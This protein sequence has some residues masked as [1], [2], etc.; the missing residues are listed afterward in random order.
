MATNVVSG[1][2]SPADN[3]NVPLFVLMWLDASV[4]NAENSD[5]QKKLATIYTNFK[6]FQS[7]EHCEDAIQQVTEMSRVILIVSGAYGTDLVPRIHELQQVS[8][9][10]VFCLQ[11]E[12]YIEFA[13]QYDKIKAIVIDLNALISIIE[14]DYEQR[15][16]EKNPSLISI[17]DI[18]PKPNNN[19][20]AFQYTFK[21]L[22]NAGELQ[23]T[24]ITMKDI[25]ANVVNRFVGGPGRDFNG[26]ILETLQPIMYLLKR[27]QNLTGFTGP[28]K[29]LLVK[30]KNISCAVSQRFLIDTMMINSDRFL[31]RC[32]ISLLSKR[33]PVPMVQPPIDSKNNKYRSIPSIIHIWDY[34]R[35]TLL[36]FGI[37]KCKGKTSLINAVFESN[38]EQSMKDKY[39]YQ[40][41][42]VDFGYNFVQRRPVN[43]ADAHGELSSETLN[44]ISMIF[45]GFLV[46]VE[47]TYLRSN[48][49]KVINYIKLVSNKSYV[50]LLI[51]DV[52]DETDEDIQSTT[53]AIQSAC[54]DCQIQFLPNVIDKNADESKEKV[55]DLREKI[56]RDSVQFQRLN[57]NSIR[58]YL[59]KL[60]NDTEKK[61]I[62][63]D[64]AFINRI[65]PILINGNKDDYPLYSLYINM[66][67]T[68][69]EVVKID[70][71]GRDFQ[72]DKL[73]KLNDELFKADS[74]F[75][76][77][78]QLGPHQYGSGF[79][80]FLELL[81]S[82]ESRLTYLNLLSM[83]LKR[84][85]E[86]QTINH[87]DVPFYKQLSL[88]IHWRNAIIG[89]PYLSDAKRQIIID[90]YRDYIVAGN[91]FEIVD[92][93]NFEMQG[94][95][96]GNVFRLFP[97]K[98]FFVISVI[99]PQNSGKSTLLNFLFGTLFEAR[100]GRCTKG[101][102]GTLV[103]IQRKISK[104]KL[105]PLNYDYI[106]AIDT[107]GL[108][109]SQKS[110]EPYDKKLI[111][112]CLA[113][114]HLVIVNVEG[115]ILEPVKKCFVLCAQALK[116]LGE[117]RVR[118]P[119]VHFVLNKRSCRN[120]DYCK[121]LVECV[122][123]PLTE[124]KLNNE[125]N[126]RTEN[127]HILSQAFSDKPFINFNGECKVWSTVE[128][129]VTDVQKIC[130]HFI[131]ISSGIIRETGDSFCVPSNWILFANRV[132]QTIK[133]HPDLTYFQDVFERNQYDKIRDDIRNDFD[134]Y[135][136][137]AVARF[138]LEK[139]KQNDSDHIKQSFKVE[140]NRMLRLLEDKLKEHC[141]IHEATGNI[142]ERS[143][144][145]MEVQL[146][147]IFHSWEVSAVM[148]SERC[149]RD[150]IAT[151]IDSKLRQKAN[152]F[153]HKNC[154]LD[155]QAARKMFEIE[156]DNL[157][158]QIKDKF[159]SEIVWTTSIEIVSHLCDVL[160]TDALP[161]G[162]NL[163]AYVPFL[164][165]LDPV[166]DHPIC[167]NDC[168][169]KIC[170]EC[171][172]RASN[173]VPL[174]PHSSGV[175][176]TISAK[177]I[178]QQYTYL[179][180]DQLS[181]IFVEVNANTKETRQYFRKDARQRYSELFQ[182]HSTAIV[183][184][185]TCF[186]MLTTSIGKCLA[187][188]N[189]DEPFTE[190][191]FI[192][193]IIGVVNKI[194]QEFNNEL[195]VFNF[196]L[197]KQFC[198][199]LYICTVISAALYYY[200]RQKTHFLDV[201]KG[202]HEN[203][204]K[205]IEKFI[206]WVILVENDD[207]HVAINL[208][209]ELSQ[210]LRQS[211]E[212]QGKEIINSQIDQEMKTVSRFAIIKELDGEVYNARNDWL[213]RYVLYPQDLIIERF[214]QKWAR[215]KGITDEK[216]KPFV[217][218]TSEKLIEIFG[219]IK[220]INTISQEQGGHSLS[221]VEDLFEPLGDQGNYQLTDKKFCMAK[222]FHHYIIGEQV[223]TEISTRN[224]RFYTVNDRWK[225]LV[226]NLPKLS[227]EIK[228]TFRSLE[229]TFETATIS[230]FGLFLDKILSEQTKTEQALSSQMSSFMAETYNNIYEHLLNQI[231]RCAALCP[232]CKRMCDV[233][234]HL[235]L[236][237]PIGQGENRHRCQLG[238]QI[239]GMGGIY[240]KFTGEAS[241][242]W[243]E[244]IKDK[245]Q[246]IISDK[247]PQ[248][249]NSFKIANSDWDFGD[250]RTRENLT[251]PY[252]Y[253]WKQIGEQLCDHYKNGMKFV[254]K[255]SPLPINHFIFILDHSGS[256]NEETN[257]LRRSTTGP[258]APQGNNVANHS[259]ET[260][261]TPWQHLLRAVK[262]FLDIRI[263]QVSFDDQITVILFGKRATR[264]YNRQ[265]L[266][267]IDTDRL[268]IS[269]EICGQTTNYSAAFQMA[270]NTLEEVNK[271]PER[272]RYRQTLI[273]MTDGEPQVYPETE[274]QQLRDYRPG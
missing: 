121:S 219:V 240:H 10:Y 15:M 114:S 251:P 253:M 27:E 125:I 6:T 241:V 159:K 49:S 86:K 245:D 92:G 209:A 208:T 265:K 17:P 128:A 64:E 166:S 129:F 19:V 155:R 160:N 232:C 65:R 14:F 138:L 163:L 215:I 74:E 184:V 29:R 85:R 61:T 89:S 112:F 259:S 40:T 54:S 156:F 140:Y 31:C 119:T 105:V 83:A 38:F 168:L 33:N 110:D 247:V 195:N 100:D 254:E 113:V 221:F 91:P 123:K 228:H 11:Q 142:R 143:L 272:N 71:Y 42:D 169:S 25:A 16:N 246:V 220:T 80:F 118:Q 197:S 235:E 238:H 84:E 55:G 239:R 191:T 57:E 266:T 69:L 174:I 270:I 190:I 106:L 58:E 47:S 127:F 132:L 236:T 171:K 175:A 242:A 271:N 244:I 189:S 161:S 182:R 248:T 264:I 98:K 72:N 217:N 53:N 79:R 227:E 211:F 76:R 194:I 13:K 200:N 229:S 73:Y 150:E 137:P 75:K 133:K 203:K 77:Q 180:N 225:T 99:G 202:V 70:P 218:I 117:T 66:C 206:P 193:E 103:N 82:Q 56:C 87:Q 170:A 188:K 95:F 120:E 234:H 216:L 3:N 43:I 158:A 122:Q 5:A 224:S 20:G 164:K 141:D 201:I 102:Y 139:E 97:N 68:R 250:P 126:L 252:V 12:K 4:N 205:S 268:N 37:G 28:L 147:S 34:Q 256:M 96:L 172:T 52:E 32:L 204:V 258:A 60:M 186:E 181:K 131:D 233:D 222:L 187:S 46:H 90:T 173:S 243:C 48:Q 261:L 146:I 269:M 237:S 179:E 41:I 67:K 154:L 109:S 263:R 9:I 178:E 267:E 165:T 8:S 162:D 24:E 207:E 115:E 157:V 144:K 148:K 116:Y 177:E 152:N 223:L 30:E 167:L 22:V 213:M 93:D 183:K 23:Y 274:L 185:S 214:K 134:Q 130:Q 59:E 226:D 196:C 212:S 88:E 151:E 26:F 273:F 1:N 199:S 153:T 62:E 44:E 260:N 111:L 108:L 249:W 255:N 81:E 50:L 94:D 78:L 35:P 230:Y 198:S 51:R 39:F 124:N 7:V 231:Q 135:L 192:Q 262:G 63:Q 18:N 257:I 107:E 145:F 2:S 136:S 104:D 210:V 36:S 176:R 149:K 45:N 21:H 101:I